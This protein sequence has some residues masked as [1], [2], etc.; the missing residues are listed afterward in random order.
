M[1]KY[2]VAFG[3]ELWEDRKGGMKQGFALVGGIRKVVIEAG[4]TQGNMETLRDNSV[5]GLTQCK[6]MGATRQRVQYRS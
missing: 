5:L 1:P 3:L 2:C 6:T 4:V